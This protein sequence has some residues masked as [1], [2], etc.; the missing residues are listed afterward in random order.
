MI[1]ELFRGLSSPCDGHER[2][3]ARQDRRRRL[4]QGDDH[5]TP[6]F[7]SILFITSSPSSTALFHNLSEEP[8]SNTLY[9]T[10]P[11]P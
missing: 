1:S 3:Q 5:V 10:K 7:S 11:K 8:D 6:H 9:L 4:L 2:P